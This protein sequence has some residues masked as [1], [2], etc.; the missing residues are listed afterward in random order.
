MTFEEK[1]QGSLTVNHAYLKRFAI[2]FGSLFLAGLH[3]W[4]GFIQYD[5][6]TLNDMQK[7]DFT[8]ILINLRFV[9]FCLVI[10]SVPL[11]RY[12]AISNYA[13]QGFENSRT[14]CR[15][16]SFGGT[17]AAVLFFPAIF[18]F[19]M[20]MFIA[21]DGLLS[22][23]LTPPVLLTFAVGVSEISLTFFFCIVGFVKYLPEIIECFAG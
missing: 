5:V 7:S 10:A 3:L 12:F 8:L 1:S 16:N 17:A 20:F 13:K 19:V 21:G 9:G 22:S 11:E 4:A 15:K 14:E 18:S 23:F 2:L 6:S